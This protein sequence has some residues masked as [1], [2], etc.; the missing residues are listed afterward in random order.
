MTSLCDFE[1]F[2]ARASQA[3]S[4]ADAA[5]VAAARTIHLQMADHYQAMANEAA[6]AVCEGS[7]SSGGATQSPVQIVLVET[8]NL[9]QLNRI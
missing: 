8:G 6:R 1:Y 9:H 7:S 3:R 2:T 5:A 4:S